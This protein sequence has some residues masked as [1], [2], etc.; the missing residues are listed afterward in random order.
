MNSEQIKCEMKDSQF[1]ILDSFLF[2][3]LKSQ[4]YIVCVLF[5]LWRET[6]RE[7][8]SFQNSFGIITKTI[9]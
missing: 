5:V 3:I 7:L 4:E 8:K 6:I 1:F 9:V 2:L